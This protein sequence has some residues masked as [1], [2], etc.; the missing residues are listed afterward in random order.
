MKYL[1]LQNDSSDIATQQ[2]PFSSLED[3]LT[4][5]IMNQRAQLCAM[6]SL[7]DDNNVTPMNWSEAQDFFDNIGL[8]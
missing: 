2:K 1:G 3:A 7:L 6:A 8:D 4:Q 5:I